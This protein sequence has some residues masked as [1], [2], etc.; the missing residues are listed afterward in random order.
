[1]QNLEHCVK[2]LFFLSTDKTQTHKFAL[3]DILTG[4]AVRNNGKYA[5]LNKQCHEHQP[6]TAL[7]LNSSGI[8]ALIFSLVI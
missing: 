5:Y 7:L 2:N 4:W 3:P 8:L 6:Q 1:V